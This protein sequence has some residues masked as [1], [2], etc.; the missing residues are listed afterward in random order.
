MAKQESLILLRG[1]IENLSFYKTRHDGYLVRKKSTLSAERVRSDPAFKRTRENASEFARAGRAGK[2]LRR[3][4]KPM[5]DDLA[6]KRVTSRLTGAMVKVIKRDT[7][8]PR[9]QRTLIDGDAT[10]L[11][12]FQFNRNASLGSS[13]NPPF[14][15]SIDRLTGNMVVDVPAFS[16]DHRISAPN[17]ATHFRLR[18]AGAALNFEGNT[19]EVATTES[20]DLPLSN[21]L[22]EALQLRLTVTPA[23]AH[24]LFLVLGIEFFDVIKNGDRSFLQDGSYNAMAIVKIDTDASDDQLTGETLVAEKEDAPVALTAVPESVEEEVYARAATSWSYAVTPF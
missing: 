11:E 3:A 23:S 2:L 21:D 9:G 10:L 22:Q 1:R 17:G 18:A 8:N 6:D 15:A 19:Y 5:L 4:F 20:A 14:S 16:P 13:F 24:P 7:I 12:E